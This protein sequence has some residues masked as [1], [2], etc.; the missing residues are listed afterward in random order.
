MLTN[1]CLCCRYKWVSTFCPTAKYILKADDDIF[2]DIF[3]MIDVLLMELITSR[4]TYACENMIGNK[5]DRSNTSKWYVP[6]NVFPDEAYPAFC[7]GSAYLMKA[8]DAS[9]IYSISNRITFLWVDD[10]F[11][12]GVLRDR[13]GKIV[14]TGGT[15]E[16]NLEIF[17]VYNRHH[18]GV[19]GEIMDWCAKDLSTNQLT[20][21]FVLL[22]KDSFI[23]DMFCVWN[24][25]RLMR[26]AMNLGL[27]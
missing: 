6:E 5:P 14:D 23:R 19:K 9:K 22:D 27:H 25:V 18:L 13:Y 16:G 17:S 24:K 10:A 3:Q 15:D 26:F 7:S 4:K 2:V 11:V 8:S 21:I 1:V 20:F 12:T